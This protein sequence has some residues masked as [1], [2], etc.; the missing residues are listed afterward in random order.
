[1]AT[2][3]ESRQ[4][5]SPFETPFETPSENP[6]PAS[7]VPASPL[8]EAPCRGEGVFRKGPSGGIGGKIANLAV[9]LSVC[10]AANAV[11]IFKGRPLGVLLLAADLALLPV[12]YVYLRF[13]FSGCLNRKEISR[14]LF[15]YGLKM[16]FPYGS[17]F[18][19][20]LPIE[21]FLLDMSARA[22]FWVSLVAVGIGLWA[23]FG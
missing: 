12:L 20:S 16:R 7:T 4:R 18:G 19:E 8:S 13:R 23:F 5:H 1:M 10:L 21:L 6:S 15:R 9:T 3:P 11:C 2:M 14:G 22:N 17:P